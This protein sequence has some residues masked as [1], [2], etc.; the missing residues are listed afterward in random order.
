MNIL[1]I[2][3]S[4]DETAIALVEFNKQ[5][6]TLRQSSG[7]EGTKESLRINIL[8]D[9]VASQVRVHEPFGGVVPGLA[10]REHIKNLPILL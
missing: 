4:C 6:L 7:Q 8:A 1:G 5:G 9:K 10:A 2:E 3:T